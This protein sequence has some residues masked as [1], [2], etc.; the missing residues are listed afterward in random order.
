M[1]VGIITNDKSSYS[2]KRFQE[3]AKRRGHEPR[4]I[5]PGHASIVLGGKENGLFLKGAKLRR[6]DAIVP[7]IAAKSGP[8]SLAVL[9]QFEQLGTFCL[10]NSGS[11]AIAHDKLRT[12]Q[13]MVRNQIPIPQSAWVLKQ[14]D[15]PTALSKLG[16]APIIIKIL[17]GS[18]GAGVVLAETNKT[19]EAIVEALLI[20]QPAVLLQQFVKESAGSDIRAFVVGDRVVAS[21]KRTA[22]GGDFRSNIHQGGSAHALTLDDHTQQ[23]A[24][25]AAHAVGL[26]VAGVDLIEGKNG[27]LVIE[28]NSS[29][30]LEG[31]EGATGMDIAGQIIEFLE[32]EIN[33][34]EVDLRQRLAIGKDFA[35]IEVTVDQKSSLLDK[36][37]EELELRRRGIHLLRITRGGLVIPVPVREERISL[38]DTLLCFGRKLD[39]K[40][41]KHRATT[42]EVELPEQRAETT[43]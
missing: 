42:S 33:F 23:V 38:G 32:D 26:R 4:L 13:V 41:L 8:L 15:I 36:T 5:Q 10:N 43:A 1:R 22:S 19:A 35:I 17:S 18:Q 16:G 12:A 2:V 9:R 20:T 30:G 7:R 25:R 11:I 40:Y 27:P 37:I 31:I 34:P 29:P 39:L 21:M 24:I 6:L 28:V 14:S 3:T